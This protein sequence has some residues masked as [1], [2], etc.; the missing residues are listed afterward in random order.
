MR[1]MWRKM[2]YAEKDYVIGG[3][4]TA[5]AI[6]SHQSCKILMSDQS[7]THT[8]SSLVTQQLLFQSMKFAGALAAKRHDRDCNNFEAVQ[9][10]LLTRRL[11][12]NCETAYGRDYG[13]SALLAQEDVVEAFRAS[14]PITT[15]PHYQGYV[16]R[17]AS[18]EAKVLN[19]SAE[20][21][22]A[23]TSGTS[24]HRALLP[25]T[26]DMSSTFFVRGIMVVFDAVAKSLPDALQLQKTVKLAFAP[27]WSET[28]GG[29]RV[30][31]NSSGPKDKSFKRLL[32]LYST[33]MAGYEIE[34]DEPA[35]MYVHALFAARD[36]NLGIIEANFVSLPERMLRLLATDGDRIADDLAAG[37]LD[38]EIAA[39]LPEKIVKRLN[40]ELGGGDKER[41]DQ[42]RQA[43]RE[44]NE[45]GGHSL[46]LLLWPKL[47][48][49][50]S[51]ATGAFADYASRLQDGMAYGVPILSTVYA[52]SEGLIGVS[53][54]PGLKGDSHYC[55]VPRA[56][57]FE[58]LP[59]ASPDAP[60]QKT[61]LA[62]E[63]TPG[64]DYELV[65]TN[66]GGLYR[67]RLGDV[68]KLVKFHGGAPVVEF[69][70]RQGQLL[71]LRGEKTSEPQLSSAVRAGLPGLPVHE[72]T[73]MEM[74]EGTTPHY[75]VLVESE[76]ELPANAS[77][78][79]E[80][81][82]CEANPVYATWRG[83]RAIGPCE[84]KRVK[85]G[86][87]EALRRQRVAEGTSPQQLKVSRVLRDKSH[88]QLLLDLS[89]NV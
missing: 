82:L 71:N 34:G 75:L 8:S 74:V 14:Q 49:I 50:L 64:E 12:E 73:S 79:L 61:L 4:V 21:M 58:F 88:L 5:V 66:L 17:I 47:K 76:G 45:K 38:S 40:S 77:E 60:A 27:S 67:Y 13:F 48:L 3:F 19:A 80:A 55:L 81:A 44:A 57:F 70:Y 16:E 20:T 7:E 37:K 72:Y 84:L 26:K 83:K 29:L 1:Q 24:G 62:H 63:L 52:A 46:A 10:E 54:H 32:S 69:R 65:I 42:V 53:L 59:L 85:P 39:R 68:V 2:S 23:A 28:E 30:G 56:M 25:N 87:F 22:L 33:P 35:A 78:S 18:G 36:R 15:H 51:N 43:V 31:P 41:A 11:K 86:A 89:D 9:R 6:V